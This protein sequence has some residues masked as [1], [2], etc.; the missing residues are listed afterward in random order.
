MQ[1]DKYAR[2]I[3]AVHHMANQIRSFCNEPFGR[4][5][6]TLLIFSRAIE[7]CHKSESAASTGD[8]V[9]KV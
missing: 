4:C 7:P 3:T 6:M 2:K 9:Q 1:L 5:A 8:D